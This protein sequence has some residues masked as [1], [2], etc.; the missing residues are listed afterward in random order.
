MSGAYGRECERRLPVTS[1]LSSVNWQRSRNLLELDRARLDFATK[2]SES[3]ATLTEG[4]TDLAR[5]IQALQDAV[6]GLKATAVQPGPAPVVEA[7]AA[8]TW[9][10]VRRLLA[11]RRSR[12]SLGA[13]KSAT[14]DLKQS[15]EGQIGA[16]RGELRPIMSR[17]RA[18]AENPTLS[19]A[20]LAEGE[21]EFK[22]SLQRRKALVA[23]MVPLRGQLTLLRQFADDLQG[24][25][26]VLD[27]QSRQLLQGIGL[28]FLRVGI[29]LLII[30]IG[31][32]FWR[33]TVRRYVS[34]SYRQRLLMS[35]RNVVVLVAITLV[36]IFHFTSELATLVT[37]LGFAAAGIAFALQTVILALAGYF[38]MVAPN[39]IRVGEY[40]ALQGP[41]GYVHG[42][43]VDIGFLRMRLRELAGDSLRP[44]GRVVVF[45]NSVV[46]TGGFFKHPGPPST[47]DLAHTRDDRT[48]GVG[49]ERGGQTTMA[50]LRGR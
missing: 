3:A 4:D 19:G 15:V 13:L 1:L 50:S 9:G 40:V 38:S 31:A 10:L 35:T 6:P 7:E 47:T 36:L 28:D 8:G 20:T 17:L 21:Q 11:V 45:P 26:Q 44:T 12:S 46:F 39:G 43:V 34:D 2:L 5:Q 42:E 29:A 30:L 18:L 25:D 14:A 22:D 23:V 41:F 27:R 24:W 49:P 16:V 32:L 48:P 37:V 33:V